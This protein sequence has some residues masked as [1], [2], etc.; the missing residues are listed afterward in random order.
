MIIHCPDRWFTG[1]KMGSKLGYPTANVKI[2]D[3]Y[4]L[5]PKEGIY[6]ASAKIND[7]LHPGLL[8]IGSRPSFREL[9]NISVEM[10]I[11]D[12][13]L[14]IYYESLTIHLHKYIRED[15]RFDDL[16][17]LKVAMQQDEIQAKNYFKQ[18]RYEK[19]VKVGVA[20]AILNYNGESFLEDFLPNFIS[21]SPDYAEVYVIDN[22]STDGSLALL[23]NKFPEV[24]LIQLTQNHGFAGGYNEGLKYVRAKY[25][26]L[27]NS[28]VEVRDSWIDPLFKMCEADS[29]IAACQPKIMSYSEPEKFEYAGGVGGFIDRLYYPF[30]MGRILHTV[31][32]DQ[33]LYDS[34][35]E[36]FW[37]SGAAMFVRADLFNGLGG[38]DASY[39]AHQ[40]EIDLCWRIKRAG[41]KIMSTPSAKVFHVGGGTLTYESPRKT[42]LNFRNNLRTIYKNTS[43]SQFLKIFPIRIVLDI[44]AA[45]NYLVRGQFKNFIQVFKGY[46]HFLLDIGYLQRSKKEYNK[47]I[48]EYAI[49]KPNLA[50]KYQK[51]VLLAYYLKGKRTFSAMNQEAF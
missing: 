3:P 10:H 17:D 37:A 38:F 35:Q 31:E 36:I 18:A 2:S 12:F 15:Q 25:Y 6:A 39:F 23:K 48:D 1:Q 40:E 29:S 33:G 27:I 28:D 11:F 26:Y 8:Y 43:T 41:F 42:Y 24:K 49:G 47:L 45:F 34:A 51:S 30:C 19:E 9:K 21:N 20:V 32:K 44:A 7:E 50:G 22:A 16:E 14:S 13:D 46:I 4:K 5:I